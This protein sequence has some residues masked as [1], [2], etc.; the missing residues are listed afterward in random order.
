MI[1]DDVI[2]VV[3]FLILQNV[4]LV[5]FSM[6]GSTFAIKLVRV[7]HLLPCFTKREEFPYSLIY[8]MYEGRPSML[9]NFSD[10]FFAAPHKLSPQFKIWN[11][12]I[13]LGESSYDTIQYAIKPRD[14]NLCKIWPFK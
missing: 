13:R 9:R 14:T 1:A 8:K 3:K 11:V 5:S 10:I 6:G 12:T 7:G 2:A 4:T